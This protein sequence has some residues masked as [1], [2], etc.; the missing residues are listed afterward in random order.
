M[1][2]TVVTGTLPDVTGTANI[3]MK[4]AN[5]KNYYVFVQDEWSFARDW[6]LTAGLRDDYY[7]D[8]G[9]TLNPRVALVWQTRYDLT[10]KLLYGRA[11]RAPSFAELYAI[12]N[13]IRLGN[14]YLKPE[15]IDT[16]EIA[17]NYQPTFNVTTSLNIFRYW[18][19]DLIQLVPNQSG[20]GFISTN[21]GSQNGQGFEWQ[22]DW[23]MRNNLKLGR[24]FF[25][26][27]VN[28]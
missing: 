20:A 7:T 21:S 9:N 12:N 8:F 13:P 1:G 6:N 22:I 5:R 16:T 3:F 24:Q 26:S 25:P 15:T 17:F 28:Q 11:F 23:K 27:E 19:R 4:K 10:T 18:V 14:P 2:P